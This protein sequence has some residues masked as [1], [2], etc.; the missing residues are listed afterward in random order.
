MA[1]PIPNFSRVDFSIE[2]ARQTV[3]DFRFS[4]RLNARAGKPQ[5]LKPDGYR[6]H[7]LITDMEVRS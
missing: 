4:Y 1:T 2:L 6:M 5:R 3:P 7:A